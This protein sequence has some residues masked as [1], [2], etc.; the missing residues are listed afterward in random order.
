M[1]SLQDVL[2]VVADLDLDTEEAEIDIEASLEELFSFFDQFV[3]ER[4]YLSE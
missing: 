4:P 2:D 3:E 1:D